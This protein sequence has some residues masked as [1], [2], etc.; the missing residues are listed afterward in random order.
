MLTR[1][2]ALD[3]NGADIAAAIRHKRVASLRPETLRPLPKPRPE[4][5]DSRPPQDRRSPHALDLRRFT[6]AAIT[7]LAHRI[8]ATAS[9]EYR[10]RFGVGITDWRILA[11]LGAEPWLAPVQISAATGLDKAAVSRSLR[12]LAA[13]GLVETS[14]GVSGRR[15]SQFALTAAGLELHDRL[16]EAA[17]QRELRILK[18]FTAEERQ[19][20]QA[21]VERMLKAIDAA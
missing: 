4:S 3:E 1:Q 14:D 15:R 21:F 20:L 19:Q 7:L 17:R 10:P 18:D 2:L 8:S 9:A 12:G 5:S 13:A 6:P 16:V 11:L